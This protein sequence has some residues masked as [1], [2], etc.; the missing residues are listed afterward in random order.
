MWKLWQWDREPGRGMDR[1]RDLSRSIPAE[2]RAV[3]TPSGDRCLLV[4]TPR[5]LAE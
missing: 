4:H 1:A 5:H 2:G 3:P